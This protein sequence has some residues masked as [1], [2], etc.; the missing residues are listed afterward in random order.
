MSE[1]SKQLK[2]PPKDL[3]SL[4]QA[5]WKNI[6]L[7]VNSQDCHSLDRTIASMYNLIGLEKPQILFFDS[8]YSALKTLATISTHQL[9]KGVKHRIENKS[10]AVFQGML[11]EQINDELLSD[12]E[13]DRYY[14]NVEKL[15]F[16]GWEQLHKELK[17]DLGKKQWQKLDEKLWIVD[18]VKKGTKFKSNLEY[19]LNG[20]YGSMW[21]SLA[22]FADFCINVLNCSYDVVLWDIIQDIVVN[23]GWIFP[24]EKICLVCDRPIKITL[25]NEDELHNIHGTAMEYADGYHLYAYHGVILPETYGKVHPSQWQPQWLL[26]EKNEGLKQLLIQ[27]IGYNRIYQE[28]ATIEL[29]SYQG[30]TLLKVAVAPSSEPIHLLKTYCYHTNRVRCLGIPSSIL[31]AK[32]ALLWV[33]WGMNPKQLAVLA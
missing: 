31:S 10:L 6:A 33:N 24:F 13:S 18:R 11:E 1:L 32:E 25:N 15:E 27:T 4:Y 23:S 17:L 16:L 7:A 28:L 19:V 2:S 14:N 30:Y 26:S 5:K 8:P 21:M 20:F 22:F 29:D 9:G 3:V 12:I